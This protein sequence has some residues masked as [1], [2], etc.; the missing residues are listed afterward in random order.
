MPRKRSLTTRAIV[1]VALAAVVLGACGGNGASLQANI[2]P[3]GETVGFHDF[4]RGTD[5][6]FGIFICTSGGEVTLKS[7]EAMVL[8]GQVDL[9]GGLVYEADD[10]FVGAA[11]G[12]PPDGI[13]PNLLRDVDGAV[14]SIDCEDAEQGSRTQLLLGVNRLGPGGGTIEGVR[15]R[16]GSGVLDIPDFSIILCGDE[17]EYCEAFAPA[18]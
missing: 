14:V 16:H 17:S 6:S 18:P 3:E 15:V 13:D 11:H 2:D 10:R 5:K 4:S 9:M 7:V 1:G 12:F 8:E